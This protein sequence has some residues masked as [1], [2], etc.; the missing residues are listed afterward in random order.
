MKRFQAETVPDV[1]AMVAAHAGVPAFGVGC[2]DLMF[3]DLSL[4][5]GYEQAVSDM[6]LPF[7]QVK[8]N[9][10]LDQLGRSTEAATAPFV[11]RYGP[12]YFSFN[13]GAI[14]YIVLD[15]VMWHG[16]GF[17]GYV[18]ERQLRWLE[19]DLAHVERGRTVVLFQHIPMISTQYRRRNERAPGLGSGV[20]NRMALYRLLQPYKAHVM[21]GHTHENENVLEN[22]LFDHVH[23]AVCGAWWTGA[24][25]QDGSPNGYGVYEAD[26]ESLKWHYKAT[27]KPSTYQLRVYGP[28]TDSKQP[29]VLMANVWNWDPEWKVTWVEDGRPRGPMESFIANDPL[30]AK[31]MTGPA[32]PQGRGWIE[33]APTSHMFRCTPSSGAREVRVEVVDRFGASYSEEWKRGG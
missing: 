24:I 12:T 2:G 25:G 22:G 4:F 15:D 11:A 7:L 5:P 8:G 29:N 20:T 18:D 21:S 33:P 10:D 27:G 9:H 26:G 30:A 3:D 32:L 6:G 16:T 19:A 17:I 31:Q 1:K 13:V 28:G 23:G 14:H